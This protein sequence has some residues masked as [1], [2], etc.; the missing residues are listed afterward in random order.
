MSKQEPGLQSAGQS[1]RIDEA[2]MIAR[3]ADFGFRRADPEELAA[4][5][6]VTEALIGTRLAPYSVIS[7]IQAR[8]GV[9]TWV[10]GDPVNGFFLIVPLTAKGVHAVRT[11]A[12]KPSD[13][14]DEEIVR[15]G[16]PCSGVYVGVYSGA[17]HEA[18]KRV[19]T[20][21][22]VLRF[23]LYA[24]VPCFARGA[25]EDGVRSM[26]SLGFIPVEGGMPDLFVHEA[27]I[28]QQADAA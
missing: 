3:W 5:I 9:S 24:P 17:T 11:G 18:R 1:C 2:R 10:T 28:Q 15:A 13:V 23:E 27:I 22:A 7:A 4:G 14:R 20:A 26:L 19:M 8:T 6:A 12:F 16:E 21:S 25:T